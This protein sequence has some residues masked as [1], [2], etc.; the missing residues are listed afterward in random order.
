[1]SKKP[2]PESEEARELAVEEKKLDLEGKKVRVEKSKVELEE[3]KRKAGLSDGEDP[4]IEEKLGGGESRGKCLEIRR[5]RVGESL[6]VFWKKGIPLDDIDDVE[7]YLHREGDPEFEHRVIVYEGKKKSKPTYYPALNPS[8]KGSRSVTIDLKKQLQD[9]DEELKRLM[10]Q[11]MLEKKQARIAKMA[12]LGDDDEEDEEYVFVPHLG[13]YFPK[14][15]PAIYGSGVG[16]HWGQPKEDGVLSA[17]APVLIALI[18][19]PQE[20]NQMEGMMPLLVATMS[21]GHLEPK[22]MLG[23]LSPFVLEMSKMNSQ[24]TSVL[25]EG[26]QKMD[27][28][29][30]KKVLDLLMSDPSRTPDEIEKWQKWLNFGET[31][32]RKGAGI[33]RDALKDTAPP[34]GKAQRKIEQRKPPPG[35]PAPKD[36]EELPPAAPAPEEEKPTEATDPAQSAQALKSKR[37]QAF[38]LAAEEEMNSESDPEFMADNCEQLYLTLPGSLRTQIADTMGDDP[39][40]DEKILALFSTLKDLCP[41]VTERIAIAIQSDPAKQKWIKDFLYAC[42]FDEEDEPEEEEGGDEPVPAEAE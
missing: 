5:R 39:P 12:G 16:S 24:S 19:R 7:E 36:K 31:A 40:T 14:G 22:D 9:A 42:A 20:K 38:L 33:V 37:V 29:F 23:M 17:L 8:E 26:M 32:L 18:N 21:K 41:E 25:M 27:E 28:T 3:K 35:L 11:K 4:E 10:D 30:R 2:V 13:G 15:H 1:M 6:Y 34:D